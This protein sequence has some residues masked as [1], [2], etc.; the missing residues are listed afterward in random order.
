MH[1]S[2]N[3]WICN[4]F[5]IFLVVQ[6][7]VIRY[8][9]DYHDWF[10]S[11]SSNAIIGVLFTVVIFLWIEQVKR[12]LV[13]RE[14]RKY[15]S[16]AG[17][18]LLFLM[19]TRTIK[20][21][22]LPDNHFLTRYAWYLYYLPQTLTVLFIFFAVLHIGKPYDEPISPK[23]KLLYIPAVMII[24]GILTN[25]LHQGAFYFPNGLEDWG[26][27]VYRPLYHISVIWLA[28]ILLATLFV[29]F[30]RASD[31]GVRKNIWLPLIPIVFACI[32]F[33]VTLMLPDSMLS[34]ILKVAEMLC[35]VFMGFAECLIL[36]GLFPS[37]DSYDK[38]WNANDLSTG[39][40]DTE[41]NVRY[42]N[43]VSIPVP[44]EK[45]REAV[46]HSVTFIDNNYLLCSHRITGGYVYWVKNVSVIK[47]VNEKLSALGDVLSEE[48]AMRKA[49]NMLAEKRISIEQ[50]TKLYNEISD[51]VSTEL[52]AIDALLRRADEADDAHFPGIM[53]YAAVLTAFIKRYSNLILL[54]TQNAVLPVNELVLALEESLAYLKL[55]GLK[56]RGEF[57]GDAQVDK[58][59]LLFA[60]RVFEG[61]VEASLP[62]ASAML[63]SLETEKSLVMRMECDSPCGLISCDF[64]KQAAAMGGMLTYEMA[65]G[66]AFVTLSLPLGGEE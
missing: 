23:W 12:R 20:F 33:P 13:Q 46:D 63:V 29:V 31:V 53:K 10:S 47:R 51:N 25:D 37:N 4:L 18:F 66:A 11:V 14:E 9:R 58:E 17:Y 48:N 64:E 21:I 61:A 5:C 2:K 22:F 34:H 30:S 26:E 42:R 16:L 24:L 52:C 62:S 55:Y 49:E 39:I 59:M 28:V 1:A 57:S 54:G 60:Y 15:L 19:F 36:S 3:T 38:L 7:T 56:T 45:I 50:K 32:Y 41:G 40:L 6:C 8:L 65:D 35:I 27:Y 44:I 43:A